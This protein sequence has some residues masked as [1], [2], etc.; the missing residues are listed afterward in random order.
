MTQPSVPVHVDQLPA[1][2]RDRCLLVRFSQ[3]RFDQAEAVQPAEFFTCEF[4]SPEY[5]VAYL[6]ADGR[7]VRP[8]PGKEGE[9]AAFVEGFRAVYPALAA[10]FR[11]DSPAG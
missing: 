2:L 6:A 8:V 3:V 10:Q 9:F 4:W 7:T 5:Q 1:A 11:F